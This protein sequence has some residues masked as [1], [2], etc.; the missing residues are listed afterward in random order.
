MACSK[1]NFTSL[2]FMVH[3]CINLHLPSSSDLLVN[4][5]DVRAKHRYH[6]VTTLL[7]YIL[8]NPSTKA[9]YFLNIY[10]NTAFQDTILHAVSVTP[11]SQLCECC[12]N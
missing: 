12:Y 5:I 7:F 9:L 8:K 6:A 10:Y 11:T 2:T 1:V 3:H 4:A